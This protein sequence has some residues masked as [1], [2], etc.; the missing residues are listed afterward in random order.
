MTPEITK[1][2]KVVRKKIS[3]NGKTGKK[4]NYYFTEDTHAAILRYQDELEV[5]K[6]NVIYVADIMPAFS[7]LV[8]NLI[9]VYGFSV[10]HDSKKDLRHE[11][12]AFLYGMI[13]KF[14]SDKGTRAFAYFNV[15]AKHWLTIRSKQN[16]KRVQSY[17]S[18]DAKDTITQED[19]EILDR[20][21]MIPSF[22]GVLSKEDIAENIKIVLNEICTRVQADNEVVVISAILTLFQDIENIDLLNKRA[23]MLYLKEMTGFTSKQL[24]FAIAG[25][26]RHYRDI[27]KDDFFDI[28]G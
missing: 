21:N 1:F 27:K 15:V 14:K 5:D 28:F 12:V 25:L 18:L 6:K 16:M 11:C 2:V 4:A 17:V 9:N 26:K 10:V 23:I 19:S 7:A 24:S 13:H 20:H 22:E 3:R 8:E